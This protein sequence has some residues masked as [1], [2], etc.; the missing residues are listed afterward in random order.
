MQRRSLNRTY[1]HGRNTP[2]SGHTKRLKDPWN[3]SA[4]VGPKPR[5]LIRTDKIQEPVQYS[6]RNNTCLILFAKTILLK[7]A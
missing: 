7:E 6:K 3:K 1:L 2:P 5:Q 4:P